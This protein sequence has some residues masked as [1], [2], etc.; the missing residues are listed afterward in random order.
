TDACGTPSIT[1][2]LGAVSS[3]GCSRSQTRTY[4]ATDA[5]GNSSTCT[6]LFTWTQVTTIVPHCPGNVTVP[7]GGNAALAFATWI[8]GFS[9]T[10]GGCANTTVTD[11]TQYHAPEPGVTLS[12]NYTVSDACQTATCKATF[13]ISP[14][15]LCTY[16]QGAYGSAGGAMC[17]GTVGNLSTAGMIAQILANSGGS[18]TVGKPGRSVIM[19]APSA[20]DC[21]IDRLP[22]GGGPRELLAGN[23]NICSLPASYLKNGRINNSLLAQTITLVLNGGIS[24]SSGL[25]GLA[26]QAGTIATAEPQGGCGSSIP[27]ARVCGHYVSGV[28]VNTTHEYSFTPISAAVINAITPNGGGN[29]TVAGLVDLANRALANT[30]GIVGTEAGV[31]LSAISGVVD[32]IN[33]AFDE[34]KIFIGFNVAPCPAQSAVPAKNQSVISGLSVVAYPNPFAANFKIDVKTSSNEDLHVKVYDALGRLL[35]SSNVKVTNVETFEIGDNYP[36]GVYNVIVTQGTEVK[37][38][39]VIKR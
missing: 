9:Y 14:C 38:Q 7:C 39:R 10:G 22:G 23:I 16:T 29:R 28:W 19:N 5:C 26:L 3:N 20:V 15:A 17:D 33:N 11:L 2:A 32:A 18:L 4:T 31:S 8:A 27:V 34:C 30:D 21:I 35:Q 12:I 6:Q 24:A 25:S 36:T 13:Y 37:A 1:S